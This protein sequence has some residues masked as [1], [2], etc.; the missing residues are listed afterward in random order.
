MS[1]EAALRLGILQ[2]RP[3]GSQSSAHIKGKAAA[4]GQRPRRLLLTTPLKHGLGGAQ[5]RSPA[6]HLHVDVYMSF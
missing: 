5:E 4:S 1:Y 6:L 3:L 2:A